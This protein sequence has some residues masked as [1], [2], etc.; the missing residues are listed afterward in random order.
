MLVKKCAAF[1]YAVVIGGDFSLSLK[2]DTPASY[3]IRIQGH[4]DQNWSDRL[5]GLTIT[6]MSQEDEEVVTTLSGQLVD[7]AALFGVLIGL[8]DMRLPLISVDWLEVAATKHPY[9]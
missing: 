6:P 1:R 7:Q 3:L 4:L 9:P 2:N 8:Y 5:G